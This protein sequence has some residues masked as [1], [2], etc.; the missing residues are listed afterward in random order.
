MLI[1]EQ[2]VVLSNKGI[3]YRAVAVE[4]VIART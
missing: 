4:L 2:D 3:R 1:A